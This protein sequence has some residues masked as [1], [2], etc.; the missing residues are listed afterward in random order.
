[1]LQFCKNKLQKLHVNCT[2]LS[3]GTIIY[4]YIFTFRTFQRHLPHYYSVTQPALPTVATV[5]TVATEPTVARPLTTVYFSC[6]FFKNLALDLNLSFIFC[7]EPSFSLRTDSSDYL[8]FFRT[9]GYPSL[10]LKSYVCI[11]SARVILGTSICF[12]LSYS[13]LSPSSSTVTIFFVLDSYSSR[14][15]TNSSS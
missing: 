12:W 13:S 5:A 15:F 9:G 3:P 7:S 1:M 14:Y 4:D 10:F 11:I 6:N 8:S 2:Q